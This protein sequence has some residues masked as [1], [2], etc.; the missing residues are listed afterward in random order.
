MVK[1][2]KFLLR[3][4]INI[5]NYERLAAIWQP[6]WFIVKLSNHTDI[7]SWAEVVV[8]IPTFLFSHLNFW[9]STFCYIGASSLIW[10]K[11]SNLF[12]FWC[13]MWNAVF[14]SLRLLIDNHCRG[15]CLSL[16]HNIWT[17]V[18]CCGSRIL[19]NISLRCWE[20]LPHKLVGRLLSEAILN[21][22]FELLGGLTPALVIY[23]SIIRS[24]HFWTTINFGTKI[25]ETHPY[26][27]CFSIHNS[28]KS[29]SLLKW[30]DL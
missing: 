15:Y 12:V 30:S 7:F 5:L 13:N 2:I 24:L 21:L 26:L 8:Q 22:R 20:I 29:H 14:I 17:S 28:A 6:I 9:Y 23:D 10:G 27:W 25:G 16:Y 4:K 3:S 18:G 11:L 1:I 19:R